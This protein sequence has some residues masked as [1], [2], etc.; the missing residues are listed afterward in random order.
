MYIYIYF[1]TCILEQKGMF[2]S[3]G[4][5]KIKSMGLI[6]GM[7]GPQEGSWNYLEKEPEAAAIMV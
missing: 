6:E 7:L 4:L 2:S 1:Y 5:K 3:P